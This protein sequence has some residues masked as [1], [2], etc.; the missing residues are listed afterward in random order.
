[1]DQANDNPKYFFEP[2]GNAHNRAAFSSEEPALTI[3]L[4][5]QANQ[6]AHKNLAAVFVMT[7][8]GKQIAGYYTLSQYAIKSDEI[9]IEI[10]RKLSRQNE[11]PAT[12]I[13]RLAR[14]EELRHTGAGDLVLADALN[15]SLENSRQVAS[16]AVVVD[17]KNLKVAEFYKR[18]EFQELPSKPL[19]LFL[20]M[21][22]IAKMFPH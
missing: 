9:P 6:D 4:Q 14:H 15:R 13:G 17:A 11:I 20:P 16:W 22:T 12:M 18:W 19:K 8:D 2:L 10:R 21:K 1:M 3:Y 5:T 7:S